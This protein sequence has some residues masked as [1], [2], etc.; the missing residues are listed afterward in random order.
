MMIKTFNLIIALFAFSFCSYSQDLDKLNKK[1]LREFS[2][3][4]IIE[5]DSLNNLIIIQFAEISKEVELNKQLAIKLDSTLNLL[6]LEK[7]KFQSEYSTNNNLKLRVDSLALSIENLK[8]E[9]N[10][11]QIL[12]LKLKFKIDSIGIVNNNN[13]FKS[14]LTFFKQ[15]PSLNANEER[16]HRDLTFIYPVGWSIDDKYYAYFSSFSSGATYFDFRI[17]QIDQFGLT[18]NV[19][20]VE[21]EMDCDIDEFLIS[22]NEKIKQTLELYGINKI[23]DTI[24]KKDNTLF[25]E[26]G[27]SINFKKSI[28]GTFKNINL[29]TNVPKIG[30]LNIALTKNKQTIYSCLLDLSKQENSDFQSIGY[31]ES[32]NKKYLLFFIEHWGANGYEGYP[33]VNLDM[34]SFPLEFKP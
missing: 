27:I 3:K 7:L 33:S 23:Q 1:E 26:R 18:K 32:P 8:N 22:N 30:N 13:A 9:L 12:N 15:T 19:S 31:I 5:L 14:I 29:Q 2:S 20:L 6:S 4:K 25:K 11:S 10:K 34:V 21:C 28:I 16:M 24:L 17:D